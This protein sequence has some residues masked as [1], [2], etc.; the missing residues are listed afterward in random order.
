[1]RRRTL[2][3]IAEL[4]RYHSKSF[5]MSAKARVANNPPSNAPR[6]DTGAFGTAW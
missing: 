1:M 5:C 3:K 6:R 4:A 2:F